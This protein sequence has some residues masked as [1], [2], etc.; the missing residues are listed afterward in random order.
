MAAAWKHWDDG[1]KLAARKVAED[2]LRSTPTDKERA[3]A[4]ELL[5]RSK[6]PQFAWIM[7]AVVV[8]VAVVLTLIARSYIE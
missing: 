5:R 3:D 1:D 8:V 7:A 2:V 6:P 4:E